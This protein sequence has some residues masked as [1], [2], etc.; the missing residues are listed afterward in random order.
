MLL[1]SQWLAFLTYQSKRSRARDRDV[2][3]LTLSASN[4]PTQLT[5]LTAKYQKT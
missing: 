2:L 4:T 5:N 3:P 1:G